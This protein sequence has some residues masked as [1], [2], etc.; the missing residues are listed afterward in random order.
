MDELNRPKS[1]K[2]NIFKTILVLTVSLGFTACSKL[3]MENYQQLK[4]GMTYD[5]V[6][7]IIGAPKSCDEVLMTRQCSWGDTSKGI[8]VTFVAEKAVVFSHQGLN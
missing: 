6:T 4:I 1:S 2:R 5:A 3:T 8:E 7:A